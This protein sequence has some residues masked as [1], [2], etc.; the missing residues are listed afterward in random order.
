MNEPSVYG[1]KKP[2][3]AGLSSSDLPG[4]GSCLPAI[5]DSPTRPESSSADMG[6][7][8][9]QTTHHSH[10]DFYPA[11]QSYSTQPMNPYTYHHY[12]INGMGPP[13]TYHVGKTEYPYPN[14]QYRQHA[15]FSREAQS[16]LQDVGKF[17]AR[18]NGVGILLAKMIAV[19]FNLF[20]DVTHMFFL[21]ISFTKC[22][23][24]LRPCW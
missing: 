11:Q 2:V 13:G 24:N 4:A 9:G 18:E 7:Y 10:H 15:L 8:S 3:V 22:C 19:T 5:K 17:Y 16:L 20:H 14:A 21:A 12:N 6:Y 1:E 23:V